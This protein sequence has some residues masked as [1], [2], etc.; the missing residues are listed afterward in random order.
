[1][2]DFWRLTDNHDQNDQNDSNSSMTGLTDDILFR[3]WIRL[4]ATKMRSE[5]HPWFRE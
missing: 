3:F 2:F 4:T 5:F 1:M